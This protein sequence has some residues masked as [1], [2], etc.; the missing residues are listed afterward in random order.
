VSR[1]LI[2]VT[3]SEV[4]LTEHSD[5]LPE[6]DPP[7]RE[8]ALGMSYARAVELAGGLPE[9]RPEAYELA[10]PI[11]RLP[12]R[13]PTLLVHGGADDRVPVEQSR[14]YAAAAGATCELLELPGTGHFELIDPRSA[15]WTSLAERLERYS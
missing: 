4:R 15:A 11:G 1:P 6:G 12:A 13:V 10:D 5:P 9:E 14:R 3:T 8:M 7:Q 2:G